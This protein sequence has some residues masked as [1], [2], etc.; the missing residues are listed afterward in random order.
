MKRCKL[1]CYL[2]SSNYCIEA[3]NMEGWINACSTFLS[4]FLL[5]VSVALLL[6]VAQW[7]KP[8]HIDENIR[9]EKLSDTP[10]LLGMKRER[11]QEIAV[12]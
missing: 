3:L 6:V 2:E 11:Q 12:S 10:A 5:L 9:K 7:P 1:N 4:L 8:H